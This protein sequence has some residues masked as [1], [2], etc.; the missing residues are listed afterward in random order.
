M[1]AHRRRPWLLL[2]GRPLIA[3]GGAPVSQRCWRLGVAA[4]LVLGGMTTSC[5][6]D[7]VQRKDVEIPKGLE[8]IDFADDGDDS[9]AP[10]NGRQGKWGTFRDQCPGGIVKPPVGTSLLPEDGGV[11]GSLGYYRGTAKGFHSRQLDET[12]AADGCW[13][14]FIYL[15][16][17]YDGGTSPRDYDATEYTGIFFAA[18]GWTSN[19]NVVSVRLVDADLVSTTNGGSC[20]PMSVC[21][22]HYGSYIT[23]EPRWRGYELRFSEL[24]QSGWGL[25]APFNPARLRSLQFVG[26]SV[27]AAGVSFD[28][29]ISIDQVGF[30]K[31]DP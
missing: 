10:I 20:D 22:D 31:R 1:R 27:N 16:F 28:F 25:K 21:E 9:L 15:D 14:A 23:I 5:M 30:I 13:G 29:D 12:N 2:L 19:D 7:V 18:K 24:T 4:G 11:N 3:A 26:N 8:E 17:N 6:P